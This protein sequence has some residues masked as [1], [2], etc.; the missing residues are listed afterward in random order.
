MI[1]IGTSR[2]QRLDDAVVAWPAVQHAIPDLG[3]A[4][5]IAGFFSLKNLMLVCRR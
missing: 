4:R 1:E 3:L 2:V 5:P